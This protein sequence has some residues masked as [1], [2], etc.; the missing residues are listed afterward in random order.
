MTHSQAQQRQETLL[1]AL[2]DAGDRPVSLRELR[3]RGIANPA[4]MIYELEIAGY[5]IDRVHR[6]GRLVGVR[7]GRR[8]APHAPAVRARR[9]GL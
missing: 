5:E 3:E 2:R 8:A 4:A 7:L 9:F 1:K 6:H